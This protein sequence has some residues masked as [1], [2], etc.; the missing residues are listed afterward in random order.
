MRKQ[1]NQKYMFMFG[2]FACLLCMM[3]VGYAAFSTNLNINVK[4]NIKES[5]ASQLLK[6]KVV[7]DGD[8][9]Y[10]DTYEDGRYIYKGANPDNYIMFNNELWRII[11]V[12]SNGELKIMRK[13][14]I[15]NMSY[16]TKGARVTD[17]CTNDSSGC[18]VWGSK[19]TMLD[20]AGNNITTMPRFYEGSNKYTLPV[21][22][23]S[24]NTHLNTTYF[25]NL[26]VEAK[27]Q[28]VQNHLWNVGKIKIGSNQPMSDDI[29]QEK[30]YKWRGNIALFNI[31]DYVRASNNSACSN[32]YNYAWASGNTACYENSSSHN[33]MYSGSP[34]WTLT[35][36]ADISVDS[37][38]FVVSV[39]SH[40]VSTNG[41]CDQWEIYPTLYLKSDI[42]L[43][44][45]GTKT[46]PYTIKQ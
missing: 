22:E 23:A 18:N 29:E 3:M 42:V 41:A 36:T 17:Y 37:S 13:D 34:I 9:L 19:T 25:N 26:S 7:A 28:M 46:E 33:W 12:E 15:G 30:T 39:S 5:S 45:D 20:S 4:G 40:Y 21:N 32:V 27:E 14:S 31:T 11:A 8:G 43:K 16:D 1:G 35:P 24:I 38:C 6:R 44:G 10:K 2:V